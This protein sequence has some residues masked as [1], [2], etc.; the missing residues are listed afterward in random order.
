MPFLLKLKT[1]CLSWYHRLPIGLRRF[2]HRNRYIIGFALALGMTV[3][4]YVLLF[5]LPN[6]VLLI[7]F[8]A[9]IWLMYLLLIVFGFLIPFACTK[10]K[11]RLRAVCVTM[12]ACAALLFGYNFSTVVNRLGQIPIDSI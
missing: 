7:S 9:F 5:T 3:Y 2:L 11:G 12:A 10:G 6:F 1:M 4:S 8:K